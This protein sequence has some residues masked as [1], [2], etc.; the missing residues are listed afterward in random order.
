MVLPD[1]I[2]LFRREVTQLKNHGFFEPLPIAVYQL[3]EQ[4]R[5]VYTNATVAASLL[6]RSLLSKDA[7]I[8]E[9]VAPP[10]AEVGLLGA[11]PFIIFRVRIEVGN[12]SRNVGHKRCSVVFPIEDKLH[13]GCDRSISFRKVHAQPIGDLP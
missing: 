1:R 13:S 8:D 12:F 4:L 10:A 5:S 7:Y 6:A 9:H 2:E 11:V 3:Q